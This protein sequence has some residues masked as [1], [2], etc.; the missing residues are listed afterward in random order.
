M[1][2]LKQGFSN[3]IDEAIRSHKQQDIS[4]YKK[5]DEVPYDFI[6]KRLSILVEKDSRYL[7]VTKGTLP[8]V[9][10]VCSLAGNP[11]GR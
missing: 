2:F 7:M 3:P 5:T 1:P 10:A 8:N 11:T 6:R 9:L 4:G